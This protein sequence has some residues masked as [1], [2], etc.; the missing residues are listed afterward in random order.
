MSQGETT[1]TRGV[2]PNSSCGEM[3]L[4]VIFLGSALRERGPAIIQQRFT[5]VEGNQHGRFQAD[6]AAQRQGWF[7]DLGGDDDW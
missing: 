4:A 6:P 2:D 3:S 1:H 7:L 5:A